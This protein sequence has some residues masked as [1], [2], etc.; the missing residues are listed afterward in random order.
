MTLCKLSGD[1]TASATTD[2]DGEV[3]AGIMATDKAASGGSKE[4]GL[5]TKGVFDLY[6]GGGTDITAG[7]LVKLSGVNIIEG[8][9]VEADIL[10]GQ[11][12]GK[13]WETVA[14]NTPEVI[15]VHVGETI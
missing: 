1:R 8:D 5:Y 4:K 12:V 11:V 9:V 6:A 15:E 10:A 13:A 3:F 7:E 2:A 14:I